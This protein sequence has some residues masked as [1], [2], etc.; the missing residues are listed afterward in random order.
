MQNKSEMKTKRIQLEKTVLC[1]SLLM[2]D[3]I[4]EKFQIQSQHLKRRLCFSSY[5]L[6][7]SDCGYIVGLL[8][9]NHYG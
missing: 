3:Q 2:I 9:S 7:E 4:H 6:A 8:K 5:Y 1:M